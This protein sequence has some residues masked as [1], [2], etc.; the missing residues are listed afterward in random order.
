MEGGPEKVGRRLVFFIDGAARGNP[1]K[2]GAGVVVCDADGN[3]LAER[4]VFLGETTNN[5]AEYK[6]LLLALREARALGAEEVTIY[7]DSQ[8]LARQWEGSYRV[9]NPRLLEL[10][11]EARSLSA[12]LNCRVVY[13]PRSQNRTADSLANRAIDT[14]APGPTGPGREG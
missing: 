7:T 4:S 2:A 8:L 5:V 12:G 13:L 11:E 1:G 9:R 14:S 10:Y 6:A 3:V